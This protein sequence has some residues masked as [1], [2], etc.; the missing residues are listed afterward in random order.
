[1]SK[2]TFEFKKKVVMAYLNGEGGKDYLAKKY[3]VSASSG[4]IATAIITNLRNKT[5]SD[6]ELLEKDVRTA[7]VKFNKEPFQK[8]NYNRYDV[9]Q[10]EKKSLRRLPPVAYEIA[11]WI[12]DRKVYP[13]CHV[14]LEKNFYSVPHA[15]RGHKVDIRYTDKV[16]E[17]YLNHQRISTHPKFPDYMENQYSTHE[18]D[19]PDFFNQPEMND[20]SMRA[21][22]SSIGP[23]TAE[24][25]E[26]IFKTVYIKEQGYNSVLSVLKLSQ[27]YSKERLETAC[28]MALINAATPRYKYLKAILSNNQDIVYAQ[29][30]NSKT[31]SKTSDDGAYLR[32]ADYY[33]GNHN[34]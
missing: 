17:I 14:N 25:I 3:S 27:N 9:F 15:Y 29:N 7:L 23:K 11:S 32:G 16:V 34:D 1:M 4:K 12:R 13:N 21:W 20:E 2:Y 30:K 28:E 31:P 19:M 18:S 24:V 22:A 6:F 26:R 5:Y 8:R 10:E 33:G